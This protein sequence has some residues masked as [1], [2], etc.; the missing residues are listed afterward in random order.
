[1]AQVHFHGARRKMHLELRGSKS[2]MAQ[3]DYKEAWGNCVCVCVGGWQICSL[4]WLWWW[5]HRYIH[6]AKLIKLYITLWAVYCMS[7][8]HQESYQTMYT[9][10]LYFSSNRSNLCTHEKFKWKVFVCMYLLFFHSKRQKIAI[11]G[12][13]LHSEWNSL[14]PL[15]FEFGSQFWL[16]KLTPTCLSSG[17]RD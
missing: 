3:R 14:D 11:K 5:V 4:S 9:A 17:A 13:L 1:M 7:I 10:L 15:R 12:P 16:R 8:R 2:I 6:M